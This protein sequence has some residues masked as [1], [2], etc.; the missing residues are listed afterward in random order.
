MI[1]EKLNIQLDC[2]E[3]TQP[4]TERTEDTVIINRT[5]NPTRLNEW[6]VSVLPTIPSGIPLSPNVPS[7]VSNSQPDCTHRLNRQLNCTQPISMRHPA[8][9]K[10]PSL[11]LVV[12]SLLWAAALGAIA[13]GIIG[14]SDAVPYPTVNL[15]VPTPNVTDHVPVSSPTRKP[16]HVPTHK[17]K[18]VAKPKP[19]VTGHVPVKSKPVTKSKPVP[20]VSSPV[21]TSPSPTRSL[22]TVTPKPPSSPPSDSPTPSDSSS[23]SSSNS[24]GSSG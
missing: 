19:N 11:Q 3:R 14:L 7:H 24:P 13:G 4:R 23:G 22:V 20:N 18:P 17:P 12:G 8:N 21:P 15:T 5:Y 1:T 2:P 16:S 10:P 6:R 9:R